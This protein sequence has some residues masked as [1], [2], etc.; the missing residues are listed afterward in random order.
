MSGRVTM[1]R[2]FI[3]STWR[4]RTGRA[5]PFV[6]LIIATA[7]LGCGSKDGGGGNLGTF[8]PGVPGEGEAAGAV[9]SS[10]VTLPFGLASACEHDGSERV[11][12]ERNRS[13]VP[14]RMYSA[15]CTDASG[16][17]RVFV[18]VPVEGGH[19][20]THPQLAD[21]QNSALIFEAALDSSTS[22]F[23]L[24]GNAVNRTD[25]LDAHGIAVSSDCST[26]AT[27]CRRPHYTSDNEPSTA[28]LVAA[29]GN[30]DIDQPGP[31]GGEHDERH[32]TYNDEMWLYE[33]QAQRLDEEPDKYVVHKG[34]GPLTRARGLGSY[35]LLNG[36]N[37]NSYGYAVRASTGGGTR[38]VADSF[39]VVDRS[40][41]EYAIA[42]GRGYTWACGRGHTLF[43]RPVYNPFSRKYAIW[44]TTDTNDD[45]IPGLKGFWFQT[46]SSPRNEFLR[47]Q[48]NGDHRQGAVQV[49]QPLSDGNFIGAFIGHPSLEGPWQEAQPTMVGLVRFDGDT[50]ATLGEIEWLVSDEDA[51]L[52]HAQLAPLGDDRFLLGYSALYRPS[53]E[54][55]CRNQPE[56]MLPNAHH[57]VEIDA[58]GNG[59]SERATLDGVGWGDMDT[60]TNVNTGEV[61]WAY[62]PD[63]EIANFGG[64]SSEVLQLNYYRTPRP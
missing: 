47:V 52:G 32:V 62:V 33:W 17:R 30:D 23:A 14:A 57:V 55:C 56:F 26:V 39:L 61:A 7:L 41:D 63:P 21:Q 31:I 3:E 15:G 2:D 6:G 44:C 28:D 16:T 59:L 13:I 40:G 51:Y 29:F 42:P 64:C 53:E 49:L 46:E 10:L 50:G 9:V 22:E 19:V 8:D 27:L 45:R 54:F 4:S 43:N 11:L 58:Q 1:L 36:E 35:Y 38:H 37:D 48:G 34:I 60:W 24:T 12:S 20:R 18:S 25:C 5:W